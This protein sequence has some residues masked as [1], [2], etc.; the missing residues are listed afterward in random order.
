MDVIFGNGE[1]EG[2]IRVFEFKSRNGQVSAALIV[3][4]FILTFGV[5]NSART[6]S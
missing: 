5:F 3:A 6:L 4:F 1:M 2:L